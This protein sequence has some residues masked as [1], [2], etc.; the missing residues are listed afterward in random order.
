MAYPLGNGQI[1]DD[2]AEAAHAYAASF[3]PKS[4]SN[5]F[6]GPAT[7]PA[8]VSGSLYGARLKM[9]TT[10]IN[11]IKTQYGSNAWAGTSMTAFGVIVLTVDGTVATVRSVIDCTTA[12]NGAGRHDYTLGTPVTTTPGQFAYGALLYVGTGMTGGGFRVPT[13]YQTTSDTGANFGWPDGTAQP[14]TVIASGLTG[15]PT[16]GTTYPISGF[17]NPNLA[18]PAFMAAI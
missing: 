3:N 13:T 2:A 7:S 15:L 12:N 5:T 17:V 4:I 16:V 10:S 6:V 18:G 9:P 8:M 14:W 1:V 11:T